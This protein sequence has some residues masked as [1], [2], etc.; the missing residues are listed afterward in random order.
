MNASGNK[1][2]AARDM[3]PDTSVRYPN[4]EARDLLKN[5]IPV[6]RDPAGNGWTMVKQNPNRS[7]YRG[8]IGA[9][10]LYVKHYHGTSLSHRIRRFLGMYDALREMQFA[11]QLNE[12]GVHTPRPLACETG[13]INWLATRAVHPSITADTWHPAQLQE[14]KEGRNR[15]TACTIALARMI[16]KMHTAG[17]LHCDL[18]CGNILIRTDTKKPVPVITDLHRMKRHKR[19]TRKQMAQNLSQLYRDRF[20][21]TTRTE[22]FRFLKHYLKYAPAG[23]SR[24]GWMYLVELFAHRD[25]S[26]QYRKRDRRISGNNSYFAG[27]TVPGGWRGHVILRSKR[28]PVGTSAGEMVF[29][30]GDWRDALAQP[31]TLTRSETGE[32]IKRSRS[33]TVIHRSL[34]VGGHTLDVYVKRPKLKTA[35][36]VFLSMFRRSRSRKAFE[37]G[38]KLLTRNIPAALPLAALERRRFFLLKDSILIT[39]AVNAP[40][41]HDFMVKW[42]GDYS[43]NDNG[44]SAKT[45]RQ[46]Y[47]DILLELGRMVQR[48]H[49]NGFF[50]RDLKATNIRVHWNPQEHRTPRILLVDLDGMRRVSFMTSRRRFRGVMRLNVSLL[51]CPP[52][53]NSGRLRMLIGYLNRFGWEHRNFKPFWRLIEEWSERKLQKQ[54]RSRRR[55]QKAARKPR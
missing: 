17:V 15:V 49:A 45:R 29:T 53:N 20:F 38:H 27:L 4:P 35:W 14:G 10:E 23:G 47:R 52:V 41:L 37:L 55:R 22:R 40:H 2:S 50:H 42:F 51:Q 36:K 54:I 44:I 9:C 7:V 13:T 8:R 3:P 30:R 31:E 1:R 24:W 32:T 33:G 19:L 26:H 16:G 5:H 34:D 39:E 43:R 12:A 18:H 46:L 21:F 48:L 25:A 28:K 6:L 11:E